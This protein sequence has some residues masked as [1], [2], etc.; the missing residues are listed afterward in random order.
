[1]NSTDRDVI[2][3]VV[4]W[5]AQGQQG[6]LFTVVKTWGSA[7]RPVGSLLAINA[8]GEMAGSVSG[9]CIEEDLLGRVRDGALARDL[10]S[11]LA[12]GST[13]AEAERF[14]LPCGGR[15]ELVVEPLCEV[16]NWQAILAAMDAGQLMARSLDLV[17]GAV[18]LE[19]VAG[20][21]TDL[22][23]V[24]GQLVKQFG[25]A[26]QMLIIGAGHVAQHLAPM[27]QALDYRVLVCE[28]RADYAAAWQLSHTELTQ[29]MPDDVV[30]ER[31][32]HGRWVVLALT[33]D[34]RLDD[35]ALMEALASPASYVGA[36]GSE[37]SNRQRRQRLAELGVPPAAVAR[38]HG[39]VGLPIGSRTPPEIAIAILADLIAERRGAERVCAERM[40]QNVQDAV[41]LG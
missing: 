33:H 35:M 24:N 1:M 8:Q 4:A 21:G 18:A 11:L 40:A 13:R 28:P 5:L 2:E 19:P 36:L 41:A 23:Y 30:R 9:G 31:V 39:P 32:G 15:L 3:R 25:A 37:R 34:P 7:P 12:Y 20:D 29:A 16:G 27:A 17:T 6:F 10:P 26:W 38:L 22:L 14:G